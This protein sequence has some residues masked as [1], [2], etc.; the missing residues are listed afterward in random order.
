MKPVLYF[1]RALPGARLEP[2][3]ELFEIRGN[4]PRPPPREEWLRQAAGAAVLAP[5]Y[6]DAIDAAVLDLLPT[7][8]HVASYGVGLNHVDLAACR[9]RGVLVTNTPGVLADA[10]A[11]MAMALLLAAARRVAEGDRAVRAG[12]WRENDPGFMLGTG[13]TGKTLGLVGMGQIGQA[14]VRRAAGFGLRL[15]YAAPRDMG[16]PGAERVPLERL[17]AESDFVSLHCPLTPGTR[18]LMSRERI[19][20]MRA[21]A[22]L[23]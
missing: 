2:L 23:V 20:S 3:R 13:I 4:A 16:V 18:G 12:R 15:L 1:V 21:G 7:V 9:A 8:R 6:L 19:R 14:M 17:L 11:D 10:T 22:V 5:T